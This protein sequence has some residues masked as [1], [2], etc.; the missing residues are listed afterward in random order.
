MSYSNQAEYFQTI[1]AFLN[2]HYPAHCANIMK[3]LA[4][5][6]KVSAYKKA[7]QWV[8]EQVASDAVQSK[9]LEA[10]VGAWAAE[11]AGLVLAL[12]ALTYSYLVKMY[13]ESQLSPVT[14]TNPYNPHEDEQSYVAFIVFSWGRQKEPYYM[15]VR[16]YAN[17]TYSCQSEHKKTP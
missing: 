8:V 4:K 1:E 13:N 3:L 2:A 5:A 9:V 11:I 14:K 7:G 6:M 12:P 17:P 16:V 10:G 15:T